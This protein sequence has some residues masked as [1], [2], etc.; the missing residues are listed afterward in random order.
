MITVTGVKKIQLFEG[1]SVSFGFSATRR[2]YPRN[3]R[4]REIP[5][6]YESINFSSMTT[7]TPI[8]FIQEQNIDNHPAF[9]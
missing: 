9:I 3:D 2:I 5:T 1:V 4:Q 8:I 7:I 6:F